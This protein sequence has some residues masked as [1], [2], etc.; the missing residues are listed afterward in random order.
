MTDIEPWIEGDAP[1]DVAEWLSAARREQPREAVI[2]RC[3]MLVA[4]GGLGLAAAVKPLASGSGLVG[5]STAALALL[6]WGAGGVLAG[7]LLATGAHFAA[8]ATEP[9]VRSAP[10]NAAMQPVEA[11]K[12]RRPVSPPPDTREAE[13][14]LTEESV[15][16]P[17]SERASPAKPASESAQPNASPDERLAEE[18]ALID[19][20]RASVDAKNPVL[21]G[22]LLAE[23]ERRFGKSAQL[24]P[25]ARYLRLEVMI[26]TGRIEEARRLAK[27][28]VERDPS[29]PHAARA[30]AFLKESDPEGELRR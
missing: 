14:V 15:P 4:A 8:I 2:E 20:V 13:P 9:R 21:A 16:L 11:P 10:P 12:A 19:R 26:A 28:I 6:K 1:A 24:A 23:H 27:G 30:R 5:S 25:E 17:A 7:S 29:G 3:S 18:L 22:A